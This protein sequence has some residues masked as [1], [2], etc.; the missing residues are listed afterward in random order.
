MDREELVTIEEAFS[1]LSQVTSK[2]SQNS[3]A[4]LGSAHVDA[5]V[6]ILERWP[7]SQRFPGKH[8]ISG[9]II[10]LTT[11]SNGP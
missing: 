1:Y 3:L 6:Q 2:T 8:Y 9:C 7:A 5:I 4:Q 10:I 11:L